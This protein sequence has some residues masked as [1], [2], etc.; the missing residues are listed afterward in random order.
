MLNM[1]HKI[2]LQENAPSADCLPRAVCYLIGAV[3]GMFGAVLWVVVAT[4]TKADPDLGE[5][6][7]EKLTM[8][9]VENPVTAVLLNF[10]SYDTLLEVAVLMIVAFALLPADKLS[11]LEPNLSSSGWISI[12]HQVPVNMIQEGLLKWLISL[13]IVV[14]GYL[15]WTGAYAPGGAF[16]AGAVIAGAGVALS[17]SGR[18]HINWQARGVRFVLN[19]GLCVFV[20]VAAFG[21]VSTGTALQYPIN[22]AGVLILVVEVAATLSIAAILLL[23]FSQLNVMSLVKHPEMGA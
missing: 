13:A 1:F 3:V 22:Y 15:L 16:Q 8:S 2:V 6:A 14:G 12:D 23:L 11:G 5:L 19:L 17:L 10:R 20:V 9:G 7:L 4:F 18:H 21:A